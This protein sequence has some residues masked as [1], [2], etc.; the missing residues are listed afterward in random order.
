MPMSLGS[1]PGT[2]HYETVLGGI[3]GLHKRTFS[4]FIMSQ[5]EKEENNHLKHPVSVHANVDP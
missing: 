5:R 3:S 1:K 4:L 2:G